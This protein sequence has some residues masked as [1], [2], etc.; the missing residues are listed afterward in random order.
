MYSPLTHGVI[1]MR[2]L[3][4]HPFFLM[5]LMKGSS[6][7]CFCVMACFGNLSWQYV[8][9][10]NFTVYVCEDGKGMGVWIGAPIMQRMSVLSLAWHWHLVCGHVHSMSHSLT[11]WS[12]LLL[13]VF[14]T[15]VSV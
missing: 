12:W 11:V 8:N 2:G 7:V 13:L 6:L 14:P 10:M 4:F 15:F 9:S 1:V 3:I 5:A